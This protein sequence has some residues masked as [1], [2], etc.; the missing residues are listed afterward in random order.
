MSQKKKHTPKISEKKRLANQRNAQKSTGPRTAEGKAKSAQNARTHGLFC[1]EI[2]LM[3]EDRSLFID[4]RRE[5]IRL[6]HR[7]CA[8]AQSHLHRREQV[9]LIQGADLR[10]RS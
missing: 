6:R 3:T 5:F 8:F 2:V 1:Q 10:G 4:L 9:D 7:N